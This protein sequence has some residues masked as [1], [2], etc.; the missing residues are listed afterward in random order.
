MRRSRHQPQ[1]FE[2]RLG[3]LALR[4]NLFPKLSKLFHVRQLA[5][6]QEVSHLLEA[7]LLRQLMDVVAAIHQSGIWIDPADRGF[8]GDHAGQAR[9]VLW[10]V[11]S[12]HLVL[13]T[14]A[15]IRAWTNYRS[16]PTGQFSAFGS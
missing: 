5:V 8:A 3:Q 1:Q 15:A 16:P 10:F 13:F 6:K 14:L 7:C 11:S 4:R 9:A 2:D 12:A